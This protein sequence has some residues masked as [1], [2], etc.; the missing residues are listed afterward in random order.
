MGPI[1]C[2]EKWVRSSHFTLHTIMK[3][4][5]DMRNCFLKNATHLPRKDISVLLAA[6]LRQLDSVAFR[7]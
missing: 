5:A 3:K 2:P 4:N 6:F 7:A 1:S